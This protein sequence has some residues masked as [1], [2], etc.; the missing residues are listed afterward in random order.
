[1]GGMY[2]ALARA[3]DDKGLMVYHERPLPPFEVEKDS[4]ELG[5]CRLENIWKIN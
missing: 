1:M 5:T 3:F 2:Y 4:L